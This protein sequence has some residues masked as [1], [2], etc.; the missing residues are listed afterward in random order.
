MS[1]HGVLCLSETL[2]ADLKARDAN[3]GASVLC[4]GFVNTNIA[5]AERNRP[6]DLRSGTDAV[7]QEMTDVI[8]GLLKQ[9]KQP[10][11]IA[12]AVFDSIREDRLYVLP[13][14]AWDDFVRARVEGVLG[15]QGPVGPDFASFMA[16]QQAGEQ[17]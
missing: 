17:L 12:E 5:Q 15:R 9:G 7:P 6:S 4:P 13:H 1:K 16:R 14:P 10:A 2:Y 11:E 8:E 3:I